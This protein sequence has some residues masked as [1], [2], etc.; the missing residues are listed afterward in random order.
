M[1]ALDFV[2]R[3][4]LYTFLMSNRRYACSNGYLEKKMVG[5]TRLSDGSAVPE[6]EYKLTERAIEELGDMFRKGFPERL[7]K[8]TRVRS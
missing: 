6:Y 4:R 1:A 5:F 8:Y 7:K 3:A 2:A